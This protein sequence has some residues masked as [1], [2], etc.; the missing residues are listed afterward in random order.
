MKKLFLPFIVVGALS[1]SAQPE[2]IRLWP[3]VAPHDTGLNLPPE[4]DV[5]TDSDRTSA[6]RRITRI[7]NVSVPTITV[8]SPA[9]DRNTGAAVVVCPGGGYARLAVDIEG[10]EICEWLNSIGVTG[11]MLKYRVPTREGF[12]RHELPLQD[13]QRSMGIVRQNATRWAIDSDRIGMMGFSAGAHLS[14]VLSNNHVERTYDPVDEADTLSCRP[15]FVLLLYPGYL[16]R[17][18]H[19]I[20]PE[21]TPH[22]RS[23]APTFIAMTQDDPVHVEN[24]IQYYAALQHAGVPAVMHLYPTGGHG[25]GMRDIGHRVSS[26]PDRAAEWIIDGGWLNR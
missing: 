5:T 26:W 6:G 2:T 21:V 7:S 16:R 23:T 9:P 12:E 11:I 25:Y 24:A 1:L 13:A 22:V 18:E 8:Y 4:G 19:G 20:A 10:T 14:A 15:D 3:E 17:G